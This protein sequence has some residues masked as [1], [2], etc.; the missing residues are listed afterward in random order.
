[1]INGR[2]IVCLASAWDYDPTSKHQI[3][4]RLSAHNDI[5]WVNY[6]GTR[7]PRP[8]RADVRT[9]WGRVR[10]VMRGV[11]PVSRNMVQVTPPV[12]PGVPTGPLRHVHKRMLVTWIR[13][14]IRSLPDACGKP[15]QVWTFAP[16]VPFLIGEL[17]EECFIYYCVDEHSEFEGYSRKRIMRCERQ[18]LSHADLVVT[19]SQALCHAKRA[20]RPDAALMRHGVDFTHFASAWRS[21]PPV[22]DDIAAVPHPV[23]GFFGLIHHWIDCALIAEVARQRPHYHFVLIGDSMVDVTALRA[24]PNVRLLGRRP[25]EQLPAYCACFD[26]ALMPFAQTAMTRHIN[27]VKMQEYLAAGLPVVSTPLPEAERFAGAISIAPTPEAFAI[28]CDA[29]L[30]KARTGDRRDVART[31]KHNAWDATVDRL[32]E[33]VMAAIPSTRRAADTVTPNAARPLCAAV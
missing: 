7:V 10:R 15:L 17:D 13:R 18:L 32:S 25:Y 31:V 12:I 5:V 22:P 24:L 21:A 8:T 30:D 3:M 33:L 2:V 23:F 29:A 1:M 20:V 19:S 26:V 16:D 11:E 28:A 14:A 6:H 4:K 9:A 27:P